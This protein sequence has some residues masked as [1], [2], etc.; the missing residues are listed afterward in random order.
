MS[1]FPLCVEM[2]GKRVFLAGCEKFAEEKLEKLLTFEAEIVLFAEDGFAELCHPQV[3]LVRR[4]LQDSDLEE[5]PLF[6]VAAEQDREENRRIS[7]NCRQRN[8]PV[9]VVDDPELCSFYFPA[10]IR[11]GEA[12][13]SISSGGK[14][15][16]AS[17][18]LRQR[19][20]QAVPQNLE[21]ILD[22][23]AALRLTLKECIADPQQRKIILRKAV[24][25]AMAEDRIPSLD[26]IEKMG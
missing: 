16:V 12:C 2:K 18:L 14:S 22:W 9:N 6:V 23:S 20:E 24:A 13:I 25:L 3:S 21:E 15:P 19:L 1:C 26:E 17:A 5:I 4:K 10:M 7:E 11:R 8:I